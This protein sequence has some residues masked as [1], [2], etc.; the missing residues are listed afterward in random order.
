MSP[1]PRATIHGSVTIA[2]SAMT[3]VVR[4]DKPQPDDRYRVV[5]SPGID[6]GTP[7]A[8]SLRPFWSSKGSGGFSINLEA[9]PGDGNSI[10]VD[11]VVI[12]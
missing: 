5:L 9:A 7:S 6:Q 8:G 1:T 3:A 2:G 12:R 11:W 4:F 10:V